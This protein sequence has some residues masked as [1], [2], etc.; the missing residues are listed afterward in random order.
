MPGKTLYI[1]LA[2]A[3]GVAGVAGA[4]AAFKYFRSGNGHDDEMM[5]GS[6]NGGGW[7]SRNLYAPDSPTGHATGSSFNEQ[8]DDPYAAAGTASAEEQP[9][10]KSE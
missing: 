4:A 8:Q 2:A 6:P 7:N 3:A 10:T 9:T 1:P 5:N